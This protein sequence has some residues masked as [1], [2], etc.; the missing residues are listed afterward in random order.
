MTPTALYQYKVMLFGVKGSPASFQRIIT[1]IRS[2]LER[3]VRYLDDLILFTACWE[4]R[5]GVLNQLF[6][7]LRTKLFVNL[8]KSLVVILN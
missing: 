4:N 5:T 7:C 1:S 3:V 8:L 6:Q 2:G